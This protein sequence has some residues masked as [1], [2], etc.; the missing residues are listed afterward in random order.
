MHSIRTRLLFSST[1][2][3]VLGGVAIVGVSYFVT[4][5]EIN[6][7]GDE[8]LKQVAVALARYRDAA[9]AQQQ[10]AAPRWPLPAEPRDDYDIVAMTWNPTGG[11]SYASDSNV[12]LPPVRQ[13]GPSMLM[14]AGVEWHVFAIADESGVVL[15]AQRMAARKHDAVE[16]ASSLLLPLIGLLA[17]M[18]AALAIGL[19]LSLRPLHAASS[20]VTKR[21]PTALEPLD[22]SQQPREIQPLILAINGLM[23]RLATAFEA[24][25]R[26]VFD[27]A[28]GLRSPITALRLQ[29]QLFERA[30][31]PQ[32]RTLALAQFKA[33][34]ARAQRLIAQLLDLSTV[35]HDPA[36]PKLACIDL[37]EIARSVVAASIVIA[38]ECA[39]DLGVDATAP[40]WIQGDPVQLS[41]LLSNLVENA[42]RYTPRGGVVDVAVHAEGEEV[43]LDVVDNGPGIAPAEQ[44]RVL[45]RFFRGRS[46]AEHLAGSGLGLAIVS[47]VA[48]QHCAQ[49]SLHLAPAG[50]GLLARVRFAR[51]DAPGAPAG[52]QA[53]AA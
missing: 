27:A 29:L 17:F 4:L 36:T 31:D 45:D 44:A 28:H 38:D 7:A 46:G 18:A 49:V 10:V 52:G 15:A 21:S 34:T 11:L 23:R 51:A 13:T 8:G 39:I 16:S 12:Q 42:L 53:R 2:A 41:L 35:D 33:G 9:S 6:E 5:R 47:A 37:S 19:R 30:S 20:E 14:H 1:V 50:K 25:Q 48:K 3:V 26:F 24:R 43:L 22:A 40:G 32:A